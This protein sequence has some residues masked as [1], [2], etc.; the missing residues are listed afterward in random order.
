MQKFRVVGDA[1]ELSTNEGQIGSLV[2]IKNMK[3][4]G[5]AMEPNWTGP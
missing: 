5:D 4:V 2:L 3:K 1:Q